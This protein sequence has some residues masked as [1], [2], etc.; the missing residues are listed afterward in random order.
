MEH[1]EACGHD[2]QGRELGYTCIGCPCP[3]TP[4]RPRKPGSCDLCLG[5]PCECS[6]KAAEMRTFLDGFVQR[7]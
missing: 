2:H 5:L 3:K 7:R 4:G 1:C 6:A